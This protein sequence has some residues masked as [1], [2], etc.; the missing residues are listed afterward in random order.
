M[1]AQKQGG[2]TEQNSP[3]KLDGITAS[4]L[5]YDILRA[6][7]ELLARSN[8]APWEEGISLFLV[9]LGAGKSLHLRQRLPGHLRLVSSMSSRPS[10]ATVEGT[11]GTSL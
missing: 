3:Q 5:P 7:S 4:Q 8:I 10:L 1:E 11:S 6:T 9:S 2:V